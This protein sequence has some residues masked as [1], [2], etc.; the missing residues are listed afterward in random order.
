M[1][2]QNLHRDGNLKRA[3]TEKIKMLLKIYASQGRNKKNLSLSIYS[4][5]KTDWAE[6]F[7]LFKE[8]FPYY[9]S[10]SRVIK[11]KHFAKQAKT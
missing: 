5:P 4:S 1:Y 11:E 7:L 6:L 2:H 3:T 9:S 8:S 10:S